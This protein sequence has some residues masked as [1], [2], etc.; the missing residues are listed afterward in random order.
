M[1]GRS[2]RR[3]ERPARPHDREPQPGRNT[4]E[5]R[6]ASGL[7]PAGG[8]L[9]QVPG[10]HVDAHDLPHESLSPIALAAGI[11]LLAFGVLTSPA[12]SIVGIATIGWALARWIGEMQ[13]G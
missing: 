11:A 12:F 2:R 7:S 5:R 8:H 3:R 13:H 6:A 4:A 9:A 10:G 1:S